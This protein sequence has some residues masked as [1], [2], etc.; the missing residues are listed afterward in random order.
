MVFLPQEMSPF[1]HN[2]KSIIPGCVQGLKSLCLHVWGGVGGGGGGN[3]RFVSGAGG[4]QRKPG[5]KITWQPTSPA[6]FPA[7]LMPGSDPALGVLPTSASA[8][9]LP[10]LTAHLG[11]EEGWPGGR[12]GLRSLGNT[13]PPKLAVPTAG[14]ERVRQSSDL[15]SP[16]T[17]P[18]NVP[19]E[20]R[21]RLRA[22]GPRGGL[23]GP[24]GCF[25]PPP[26]VP[27]SGHLAT[28]H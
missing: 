25:L 22:A 2:G 14:E 13:A 23:A 27:S 3:L 20:N 8:P 6:M 4:K 7:E 5:I 15:Q 21:P 18:K 12:R 16:A 10:G 11:A 9:N 19:P 26:Q 28:P 17:S 1:G 24:W